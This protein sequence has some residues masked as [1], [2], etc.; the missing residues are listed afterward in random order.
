[1]GGAGDGDAAAVMQP[2][3]IRA[4]QHE[5]VQIGRPAIFPM[6]DVMG[7]Q[8]TGGATARRHTA[9][10]AVFEGAAQPPADGAGAAPDPDRLPLAFEPHLT[11]GIAE[12]VTPV[13][14][15]QHRAQMQRR[16]AVLDI[17]MHGHSG[18]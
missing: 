12:Q 15:S 11:G 7:M 4:D 1:M 5:V 2:V 14:I 18:V 16:D 8:S 10:V 13:I 3:V 9:A 6:H 17:Q